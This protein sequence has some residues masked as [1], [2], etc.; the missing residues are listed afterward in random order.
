MKPQITRVLNFWLKYCEPKDQFKN[1]E[2]FDNEVKN[3]FGD[4]VENAL[5]GYLNNWRKY[6]DG[7]LAP[8]ILTDQFTRNIFRG[9][10]R[11]FSG[12]RLALETSLHCLYKF[13]I[14]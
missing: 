14:G 11:S 10:A 1:D 9:T 4:L 6:L 5:F 13:D 2:Y 12:D 8:I 7:T 3:N